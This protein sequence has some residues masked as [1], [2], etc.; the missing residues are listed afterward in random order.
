MHL[1]SDERHRVPD[2]E[3]TAYQFGLKCQASQW[4]K[5]EQQKEPPTLLHSFQAERV[6]E[7]LDGWTIDRIV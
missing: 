1:V 6:G 4:C 7:F 3:R 2:L 5:A